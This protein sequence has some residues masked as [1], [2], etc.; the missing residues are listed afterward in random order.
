[1]ALVVGAGGLGEDGMESLEVGMKVA[2]NEI[3]HGEVELSLSEPQEGDL[4]RRSDTSGDADG[5]DTAR[6]VCRGVS[7]AIEAVNV[8][9]KEARRVD[10]LIQDLDCDLSAM[11]MS[12]KQQ[13][14]PLPGRH[15]EDV[16][17]VLEQEIG[18]AGDD[19][20]SRRRADS[21]SRS[22]WGW[23]S[24]PTRLSVA[25]PKRR[26]CASPRRKRMPTRADWRA[27]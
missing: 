1:M 13:I 5:S 18:C 20:A 27:V 8:G 14:I 26:V 19:E 17:I 7:L 2:D 22:R 10:G 6:D 24:R 15:G 11:C 16:G 4:R 23:K 3:A 21:G 25:L 9:S 12:R